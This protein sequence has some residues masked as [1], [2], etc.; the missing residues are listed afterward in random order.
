MLNLNKGKLIGFII[1]DGTE[2]IEEKIY[3][4]FPKSTAESKGF[5]RGEA[6]EEEKRK[7]STWREAEET[8]EE[9]VSDFSSSDSE[10][11]TES[12]SEYEESP[13]KKKKTE[14]THLRCERDEH[15]EPFYDPKERITMFI[16]G[17]QGCGKSYFVSQFL[18]DYKLAHPQRPIY[19]IT[20]LTEKDKHF[21][22]IEMRKIT[23]EPEVIEGITLDMLRYADKK[24]K[25][26]VGCLLIFDDTD[27]IRDLSL[28]RQVYGLMQDALC[29]G[30]DH[31]T[32]KA[33]ADIDVVVTNHEINDY[34]NTKYI[35][36]ESNYVVLFPFFTTG[37]QIERVLKKITTNKDTIEKI[38]NYKGRA[39]IIHKVAPIYCITEKEIFLLR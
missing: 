24:M 9:E 34:L 21:D 35:L 28:R 37:D 38:I 10:F 3:F 30:R 27:R 18:K 17:T 5:E 14:F 2:T 23:M 15:I 8:S 39:V 36:T 4:E 20:G 16:G 1:K 32:Q 31:E 33:Y 11:D 13:G 29:N 25:K 19:L 7:G 26:K 12:D 22:G 6:P